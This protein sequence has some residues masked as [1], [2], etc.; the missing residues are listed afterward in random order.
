MS[1][2]RFML[3][4]L[5]PYRG[6]L[7]LTGVAILAATGAGLA[8]PYLAGKAIDS[9]IVTGDTATLD[10]IVAAFL[11]VAALY[12]GA[13]FLQT[14]LVGWVGTRALQDLRER[15]FSHLQA[16][17]IGFFTRRSPGVLISRMTN[18]I[19]A[20]NQLVTGGVVTLFSST[21]TPG[22]R[23]RHPAGARPEAG[24]GHLPHLPAA[25]R[26]QHRLPDRLPRRLPGD[27]RADRRRHRL[28]AGDAER[29]PRGAQLRPGAAARG[30]DDRA[31]RGQPRSQHEDRLPQRL[32]L[33]RGRDA[34]RGRHR[35]DPPL[36]RQ[37]GDRRG[38]PDRR[39]RRLRRLPAD[40][41]RTDPAALPALH[42]LPAGDGGARQDLRAARH[43]ARHGRPRRRDRPGG[44][45][46][47]DR[48][49]RRLVLLRERRS[50]AG[51]GRAV[52]A[53][54]DRPAA[55]Y[56]A[57][58]WRWSA[59]PAPASRPSPSWSP[60][61]TTRSAARSRSTATTCA[62]CS[63]GRCAA[64]SASS[65]RRGSCSPAAFARTSPSAGRRRAWRRS[66]RPPQ[67]SARASSSPPCPRGSRPRSASAASSSPPASASSSPSRGRCS[68]SRAS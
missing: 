66:K 49:A 29:R 60:A 44:A 68:P 47:R 19:E 37:P 33:P 7:A 8:P 50:R 64:S 65:P 67:R 5:R 46:R 43:R 20:L 11:A 15:V 25:R 63:S 35:G 18:D 57:R 52:G 59:R 48:D 16:M 45:A 55:S 10:W 4:L 58:P 39:D 62:S 42:H 61:S 41:L 28:P 17:S 56:R 27:A 26:G 21:L 23:G 30:G 34:G 24:A 3:A 12:A 54:R 38:D 1:K 53:A 40:L 6:R 31:E 9:G 2:A 36:R 14:Y 51:A 32:L 22:R 13:T